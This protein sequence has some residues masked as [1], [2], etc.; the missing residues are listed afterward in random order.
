MTKTT[1]PKRVDMFG[2]SQIGKDRS[3][4]G[5]QFMVAELQRAARVHQAS[6]PQ[7]DDSRRFGANQ[8]H[9]LLVADGVTGQAGA[10]NASSLVVDEV[11][12]SILNVVPWTPNLDVESEANLRQELKETVVR[13][14]DEVASAARRSPAKS[15]M[16]TTL[17]MAFVRWPTAFIVHA[18]DSR[19]Y[20]VP[21][22]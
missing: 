14:N 3:T 4:N 15:A 18:G 8:A 21:R 22:R 9:V 16:A 6:K 11:M 13:C 10:E 5:D 1:D 20:L 17:T 2:C 7:L 12:E 19:A